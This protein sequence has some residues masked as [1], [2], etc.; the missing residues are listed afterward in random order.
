MQMGR[1]RLFLLATVGCL[2]PVTAAQAPA[3]A[4]PIRHDSDCPY[5]HAELAA[6][7]REA[8]SGMPVA[9]TAAMSIFE[10]APELIP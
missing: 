1:R 8:S 9:S 3:Y 5:A 10:V 6:A 4:E 7:E 2:A